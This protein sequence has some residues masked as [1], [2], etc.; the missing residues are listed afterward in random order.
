MHGCHAIPTRLDDGDL[1]VGLC[2]GRCRFFLVSS[3][4]DAVV[5]MKAV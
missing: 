4:T 2:G 1:Y 5:S 3:E